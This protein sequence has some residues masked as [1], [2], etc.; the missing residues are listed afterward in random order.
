MNTYAASQTDNSFNDLDEL[1]NQLSQS[2]IS[3]SRRVA[4]CASILAEEANNTPHIRNIVAGAHF[5]MLVHL[6]SSCHDI[7]KIYSPAIGTT[8]DEYWQH[9]AAG[10]TLLQQNAVNLFD[11]NIPIDV[12]MEIVRH[13][14]E[15]SDGSGFPD[16]V[17]AKDI[18]VA[19]GICA[20]ANRLDH[21][22]DHVQN[23]S[24]FDSVFQDMMA[25]GGKIFTHY[26]LD[27]F[28]RVWPQLKEKY[29]DWNNVLL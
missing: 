27:C 22:M 12:I 16:G 5:P 19:A 14:H 11:S 7:G 21:R 17:M 2:L 15:H 13:H 24:E 20:V 10:A 6:G 25:L 9:P 4:V 18:S 28:E 8:E 29:Y 1:L 3:H 23:E 26:A